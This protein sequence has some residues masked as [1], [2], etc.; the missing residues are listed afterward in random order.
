MTRFR[1]ATYNVHKCKGA[2]WRMSPR[3]V[4]D[5]IC[6]V[7]ADIVATQEILYSQAEAISGAVDLPFA[8]GAVRRHAGEPYG[9]AVFTRFPIIS[10]EQFDLTVRMREPRECLRASLLLPP[11]RTLHFFAVHLGT[12]FFERREQARRLVSPALLG[13]PD[14]KGARIVAGDFNEWTRGLATRLL[15]EHLKS[16]DVAVHLKRRKTYPG[17]A[18]FLHLDHVFYDP[19]YELHAMSLHRTR[20]ALL[21][22][23]HLPLIADFEVGTVEGRGLKDPLF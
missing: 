9:N 1:I 8:F 21:A 7:D 16:A 20:L 18:P 22:S 23:D 5:V 2:D 13:R 3:R 12:S 15:S 17:V 6:E 4:A 11:A 10:S 19:A 14:L